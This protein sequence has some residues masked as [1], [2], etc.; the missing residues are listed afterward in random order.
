[1]AKNAASSGA[2]RNVEKKPSKKSDYQLIG[3]STFHKG[4]ATHTGL[5]E[6]AFSDFSYSSAGSPAQ[7]RA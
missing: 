5:P 6:S 4:R 3:L 7:A 2:R 1:M